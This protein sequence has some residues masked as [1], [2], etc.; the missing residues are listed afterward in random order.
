MMSTVLIVKV[1]PFKGVMRFSRKGK[2]SPRY[3]RPFQILRRIGSRA[4]ELVF[5]PSINR[6]HLVFHVSMLRKYLHD[7]SH[8]IEPQVID[9]SQDLSYQEDPVMIIDQGIS[10]LHSR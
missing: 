2:L 3:I 6:V 8:I 1:S 4:Y 5:P 7:E 10:K 9:I